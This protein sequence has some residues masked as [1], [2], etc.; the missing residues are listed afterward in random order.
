MGGIL[1]WSC[2]QR[3]M[4]LK[5]CGGGRLLMGNQQWEDESQSE[6][7]M[8]KPNQAHCLRILILT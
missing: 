3:E 7:T 1:V 4:G 6:L 2:L 8:F 5:T